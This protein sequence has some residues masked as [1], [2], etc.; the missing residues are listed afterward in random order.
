MKGTFIMG[1]NL[2]YSKRN[3][4]KDNNKLDFRQKKENT[5]ASLYEVENF[6]FNYKNFIKYVKLYRLFR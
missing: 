5:L 3:A 1:N 4:K 6:L 2:F